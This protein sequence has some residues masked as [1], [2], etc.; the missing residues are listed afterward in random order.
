[1]HVHG[2]QMNPNAA[3]DA[4]YAAQKAAEAREAAA[5]RKKLLE[6]ASAL[7]G[8][9][10]SVVLKS[11]DEEEPSR[12]P[13]RQN[14]QNSNPQNARRQKTNAPADA[15]ESGRRVSNWV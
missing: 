1:M 9:A 10:D 15:E 5:T 4:A 13:Q 12:H 3:L 6:F 2:N 7:A 14:Q 8:D 11:K